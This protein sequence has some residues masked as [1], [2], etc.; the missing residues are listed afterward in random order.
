MAKISKTYSELLEMAKRYSVD[1]NALFLQAIKQYE[2]QQRVIDM[3]QAEIAKGE[4]T[5]QKTYLA[6]EKNDYAAP[7]IKELP[8]HSDAANRT[9][10]VILDIIVKLGHEKDIAGDKLGDFL[11]K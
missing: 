11:A 7:M 6:G 3:I 4:L 8:K 2:I 9:A 1:N 10:Q 5:T